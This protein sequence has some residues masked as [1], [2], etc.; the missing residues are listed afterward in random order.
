MRVL[1]DCRMATWSG[2]GRYSTGLVR[3]LAGQPGLELVQFVAM[4]AEPPVPTAEAVVASAHP[5]GLRGALEFGSVVRAVR[6]DITHALHFPTPVPAPR[7]L[8][9]TMQ[10]VTPLVEPAV[11]PSTLKR[12]VYRGWVV[13]AVRVADRIL[14][15]SANTARDLSRF[16]PEAAG[17]TDVVLLAADDFTSQPVGVLP[18][19]LEGRRYV[20]AMGNTRPHKDLPSLLW[21]FGRLAE[22]DLLLVLA[23]EDSGG[24]VRSVLGDSAWAKRVSFTGAVDDGTLRALFA[25]AVALAY[26]SRY[27]GFGL[28]P[29]EAMAYGVPVVTTTAASIPEV[30]GDSALLVEPGDAA[31]LADALHRVLTDNDLASRLAT[32]GRE[33]ASSFTWAKTAQRTVEVYTRVGGEGAGMAEPSP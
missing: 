21:A 15:S 26:P 25:G 3:A 14:A 8:V 27:E 29:L 23:G 12:A 32:A 1:L 9:V 13:R 17:K 22:P 11:M 24:Y 19:W 16:F 31:A 7:P 30:V 2:V 5:F 20:L 18:R 4:G 10:D 6:P 33:R 28:P